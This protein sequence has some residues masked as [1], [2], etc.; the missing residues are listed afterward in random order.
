[1]AERAQLRTAERHLRRV[2]PVL[3]AVIEACGP[4]TLDADR[5]RRPF[6]ALVQTIIGQ[7]IST[8]AARSIHRRFLRLYG[9]KAP[10]ARAVLASTEQELR[11][12]GLSRQKIRTLRDLAERVRARKIGLAALQRLGDDE[13]IVRLTGVKGIGEW[14]AQ[15][16]MIFRLGRLDLL[17]V[18]DLG[19]LDGARVLYGLPQ[20]PSARELTDLAEPW[21]PYRS[22]GCW[23]L[24][25]GRRR[26]QGDPERK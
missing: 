13:V 12:V 9:G 5:C 10:S 7:Q 11:I 16:F 14:T 26:W 2:D 17:P 4:C 25:Q 21:R 20:R 24:W 1:M 8:A 6:P 15:V 23:Y 22:V 3:R 19:L 18:N